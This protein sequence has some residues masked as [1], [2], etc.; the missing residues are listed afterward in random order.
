MLGHHVIA[1]FYISA[2]NLD[3]SWWLWVAERVMVSHNA[4]K[5]MMNFQPIP[6]KLD[7]DIKVATPKFIVVS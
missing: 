4:L 5:E 3:W 2:G 6:H 7:P 1:V